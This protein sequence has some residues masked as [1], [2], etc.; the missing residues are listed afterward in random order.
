V[1]LGQPPTTVAANKFNGAVVL[2]VALTY[3]VAAIAASFLLAGR[4]DCNQFSTPHFA[5]L[6]ALRRMSPRYLSW[7]GSSSPA[8]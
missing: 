3:T 5:A 1:A 2:G 7:R 4:L 8:T 6:P